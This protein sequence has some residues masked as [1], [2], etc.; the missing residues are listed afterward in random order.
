MVPKGVGS[1]RGVRSLNTRPG[2]LTESHKL[3]LLYKLSTEKDYLTT[4]LAWNKRQTDQI[5][6]RLAEIAHAAHAVEERGRRES[7]SRNR[8]GFYG[9]VHTLLKKGK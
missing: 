8:S 4:K 9:Y 3:L 1:I 7:V 6:K 5:E 2:P